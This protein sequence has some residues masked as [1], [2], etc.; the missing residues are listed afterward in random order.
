MDCI[1]EETSK[2]LVLHSREYCECNAK[3]NTKRGYGVA[4]TTVCT[5]D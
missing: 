3:F 5:V 1:V 4:R 2:D